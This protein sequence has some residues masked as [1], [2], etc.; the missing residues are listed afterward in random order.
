MSDHVSSVHTSLIRGGRE[1]GKE[2]KER[3][4]I[5]ENILAE[6]AITQTSELDLPVNLAQYICW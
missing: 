1:G 4:Y 6:A 3:T 5:Y 2:R